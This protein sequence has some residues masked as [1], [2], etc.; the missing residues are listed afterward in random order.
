[1]NAIIRCTSLHY[2]PQ[3]KLWKGNVLHLSVGHS[4]QGGM[5]ASVHAGIHTHTHGADT[6]LSRHPPCTVHAGIRA[7]SR[8]YA[9]Y[10]NA[11]VSKIKY[12][13]IKSEYWIS[14]IDVNNEECW[15]LG[16]EADT[17]SRLV[18]VVKSLPANYRGNNG[19]YISNCKPRDVLRK[20]SF[21]HLHTT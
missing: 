19:T 5:S 2:R 16:S 6:P 18:Q 14:R 15:K 1:M 13:D 12:V 11:Y 10:R 21:Y 7:T 20:F 3:K 17:E 4:V 8:R 9:S